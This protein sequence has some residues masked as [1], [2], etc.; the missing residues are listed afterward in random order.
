[1]WRT[2]C[3]NRPLIGMTVHAQRHERTDIVRVANP[4]ATRI[5]KRRVTAGVRQSGASRSSYLDD[6][7]SCAAEGSLPR[8]IPRS[9]HTP[10]AMNTACQAPMITSG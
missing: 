9:S 10:Y 6:V 1:M 4:A 2:S 5:G 7:R 3:R 8:F